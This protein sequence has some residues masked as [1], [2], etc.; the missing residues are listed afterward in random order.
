MF[1]SNR[2]K[3]RK[4]RNAIWPD[5]GFARAWRYLGHRLNRIKAEPHR[6]ALG[7]ACG[8][9]ISFTP[10]IGLHV[11]IAVGLALL[12]RSSIL[13]ALIGTIVGNPLTFPFIWMAAFRLGGMFVF[14]AEPSLPSG[15]LLARIDSL[16]SLAENWEALLAPLMIGSTILGLFFG[17]ASYV[18]LYW[19]L[20]RA[21]A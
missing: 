11:A 6:I 15:S 8:V 3:A 10:L 4:I 20:Q 13:A 16:A 21:R 17:M 9:F 14:T 19:L 18:L 7:F 2:S 1:K 5:T 12:L